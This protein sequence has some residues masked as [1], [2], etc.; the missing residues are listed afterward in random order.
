MAR[1]SAALVALLRLGRSPWRRY[2][3][4]VDNAGSAVSALQQELAHRDGQ[5]SLLPEDPEPVIARASAEIER[6]RADGITLVTVLDHDYPQ[7]LRAVHDRPPLI[8]V[9]GRL[10]RSDERSVA[11]VGADEYLWHQLWHQPLHDA[12]R[13]LLAHCALQGTEDTAQDG[14]AVLRSRC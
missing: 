13:F 2:A 7:N 9:A 14:R 1:E 3:E 10:E 11:V 8:F 5:T 6:W 12:P 4:L